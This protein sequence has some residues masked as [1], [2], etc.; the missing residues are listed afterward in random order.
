MGPALFHGP[1]RPPSTRL[2]TVPVRRSQ[3]RPHRRPTPPRGFTLLEL[4][5]VMV[6]I[7]L[8]AGDVG[9]KLF[10]LI[11]KSESKVARAQI[12]ALQKALDQYR[13][14]IGRYPATDSGPRR[15]GTTPRR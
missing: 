13:I 12:D 1:S 14:D 3:H 8:L 11:G 10:A 2:P 9:P 15:A 5:A 4:L 7:G 6:I